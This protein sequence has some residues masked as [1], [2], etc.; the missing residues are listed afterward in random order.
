VLAAA[1]AETLVQR[2]PAGL[3][4][5]VGERGTLVSGGE[6]QRL[7]LAR[8]LLR[9]PRLLLLDEA[10]NA[11]DVEGERLVLQGL[12]AAAERPTIIMIAHRETSLAQ[13]ERI[14]ELREGRLVRDETR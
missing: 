1:G 6:R 10:T 12:Q 5:V 9:R 4:T 8:A 11:I 13:C 7:A 2:M 14:I 3:E